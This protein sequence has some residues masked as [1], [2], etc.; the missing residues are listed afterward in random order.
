MSH[1]VGSSA[2]AGKIK[3]LVFPLPQ[4]PIVKV[5]KNSSIGG[6]AN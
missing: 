1:S 6:V 3:G 2:M 5:P 4:A